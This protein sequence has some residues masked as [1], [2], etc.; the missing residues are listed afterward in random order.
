VAHVD[1]ALDKKRVLLLA[2]SG[3]CSNGSAMGNWL[4]QQPLIVAFGGGGVYSRNWY[5]PR[6]PAKGPTCDYC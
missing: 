4:Q 5:A 2:T 3:I 6:V 1:R